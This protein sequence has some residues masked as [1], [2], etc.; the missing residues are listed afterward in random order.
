[1]KDYKLT[2]IVE[3]GFTT[4]FATFE[5]AEGHEQTVEVDRH[6]YLIIKQSQTHEESY[7]KKQR[8]HGVCSF[9]ETIGTYELS[10]MDNY[11][12][13]FYEEFGRALASMSEVQRRRFEMKVFKEMTI[14]QI[15]EAEGTNIN[16]V[17]KSLQLAKEKLEFL[18][19]FF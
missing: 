19:N 18:K 9:D 8:R 16:A 6:T 14:E 5:D 7:E 4:Y 17:W 12:T 11:T 13:E 1:M 2:K 10:Y 15:A 3:Y